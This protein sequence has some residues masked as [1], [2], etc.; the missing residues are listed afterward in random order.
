MDKIPFTMSTLKMRVL[1]CG[2]LAAL[3]V[4]AC[5]VF[6]PCSVS[7]DT[8]PV[9]ND[10]PPAPA[11]EKTAEQAD[12]VVQETQVPLTD[13]VIDNTKDEAVN[14]SGQAAVEEAVTAA[15]VAAASANAATEQLKT[16]RFEQLQQ[17][18][19]IQYGVTGGVAAVLETGWSSKGT[20]GAE[21]RS[22]AVTAMPY[23]L[24]VPA[25]WW[26]PD[27]TATYCATKYGSDSVTAQEAARAY[28]IRKVVVTLSPRKRA[29]YDQGDEATRD[30]VDSL[31]REEWDPSANGR[32]GSTRIALFV[33]K[34]LAYDASVKPSS[35]EGERKMSVNSFVAFGGGYAP[36]A[37]VTIL[38]GVSLNYIDV[39]GTDAMS[40]Q[41]A[42]PDKIRRFVTAVFAI[43]GN[44][45]IVAS[46]FKGL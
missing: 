25:Y 39:K 16:E 29:A 34:P 5:N 22:N 15:T 9:A 10:V 30:E 44:L 20:A 40:D 7:A 18:K 33:G 14:E 38:A 1:Q 31:A 27:I 32:C 2:A 37:Y 4:G 28:S 23:V 6:V 45:D 46:V 3:S 42:T 41:P 26:K 21:Q 8:T 13:A 17:G 43:G 24:I 11:R 35:E 36:N 12:L 19:F